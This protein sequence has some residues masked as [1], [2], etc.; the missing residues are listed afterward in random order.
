MVQ[1]VCPSEATNSVTV[2]NEKHLNI[3]TFLKRVTDI[4]ANIS[5]VS[6]KADNTNAEILGI[7]T[8]TYL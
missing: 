6:R 8:I 3:N 4:K 5:S 7:T 2:N 1:E